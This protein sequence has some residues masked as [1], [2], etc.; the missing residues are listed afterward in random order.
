VL[1]FPT[2]SFTYF[3]DNTPDWRLAR[4]AARGL[5]RPM[6]GRWREWVG[7]RARAWSEGWATLLWREDLA[8][9]RGRAWHERFRLDIAIIARAL[10]GGGFWRAA[11]LGVAVGL[12][13]QILAWEYDLRGP[14]RDALQSLPVLL[15]APWVA[16][17]R[18][19]IL[20]EMLGESP[21]GS[22]AGTETGVTDC[23]APPLHSAAVG[24]TERWRWRR[25]SKWRHARP[26]ASASGGS[27]SRWWWRCSRCWPRSRS[28]ASRT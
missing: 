24:A 13:A 25:F 12:A 20:G 9:Y 6:S 19:R 11:L 21:G 10:R 8:G 23:R 4:A 1:Q 26:D 14:R 15:V 16:R 22:A 17:G 3:A 28:R 7:D 5:N 27:I 18:R 2:T